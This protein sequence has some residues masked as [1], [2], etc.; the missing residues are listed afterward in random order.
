MAPHA[1][2]MCNPCVF[3]P[4]PARL[5]LLHAPT[6]GAP[7]EPHVNPT[8]A[9]ASLALTLLL[10]ALG[11]SIANV[12]LPA[13]AQA[14]AA[15]FGQVQWVV[16]A[17][18]LAITCLIVSAGRLGDLLG[19][20]RVLLAGVALF[21]LASALCAVAPSLGILIGARALQGVGAALMMALTLAMVG[22]TVGKARTGSAMGLLGTLSAIGTALGPTLGGVLIDGF[23]WR[24]LFVPCAAL[25]L[26]TL[27]LGYRYL[28]ADPPRTAPSGFDPFGTLLLALAL[29]AY[30]LAMTL[31]RGSLGLLNALLLLAA[32]LGAALFLWVEARV[33]APLVH[34]PLLRA[35]LMSTSLLLNVLVAMVMMATLVV[36]P[37]YLTDAL[38]LAPASVGL[39]MSVGPLMAAFSGVPAG[40]LVDRWG[41]LAVLRLG[42]F[43]LAL[44]ALALGWLAPWLGVVGYL[45]ALAILTPGYQLFLAANNTAVM[46][47]VPT[48]QRGVVSGLL[49]LARNLGLLSGA[50]LMGTVYALTAQHGGAGQ[51]LQWTFTGATVLLGLGLALAW[52]LR[53]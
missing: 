12:G 7:Q 20:R 2:V 9:L 40:K 50:S 6:P 53:R 47:D 32:A 22:D 21:S 46:Q 4:T 49:N 43:T 24:G 35:P 19:R 48:A 14:F 30:A 1:Q 18:L 23:G 31:G 36:G 37:F 17:Y 28:P 25:G 8:P 52:R 13:L 45:V 33:A 16:L 44:G 29:G 41:A 39:V 42:L 26:L 5:R 3:R 11:S 27:A 51:G 10:C 38:G 34:L 15:P